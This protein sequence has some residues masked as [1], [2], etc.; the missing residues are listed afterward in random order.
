MRRPQKC[1]FSYSAGLTVEELADFFPKVV[2]YWQLYAKHHI[3]FHQSSECDGHLVPHLE[4]ITS[5]YWEALQLVCFSILF[6]QPE[7]LK[8]IME[9]LAY[10]NDEQDALLDKLVSPWLPDRE[11]SEVYLRQLPYRK[12][13]KV[14]TAD[15]A[16]RPALM[17]AYMDEWYG[18]SKREPYH[19]RHKSSQFPGYWSLEAAAITVILRIDDSSYR[20]K[21]YYP[22][23]LVDYA[24]SQ[25]MVLDEHGN[26]E[27]EANRLRCEAGQSCP[28]S[29]EWYSPA[30]DMQKRYFNQGEIMP[31]IKDNSWGETIWYLDLEN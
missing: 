2:E 20:D 25:Y 4:L 29:G 3:N 26:I 6:A 27:G 21:P 30:N 8:T 28:Q 11:I 16:H 19:D 9:I 18:A 5:E 13:E 14:F 24:R 31:E 10:E 7:H 22:K 15:E 12:L 17:S 23:D 1:F